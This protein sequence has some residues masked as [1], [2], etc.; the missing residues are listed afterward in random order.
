MPSGTISALLSSRAATD[1]VYR[2]ELA[3][4]APNS[5]F[6]ERFGRPEAK[7]TLENDKNLQKVDANWPFFRA[8]EGQQK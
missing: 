4:S 6:S 3:F 8:V 7:N 1:H 5:A 2:D